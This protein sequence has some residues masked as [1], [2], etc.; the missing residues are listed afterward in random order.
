MA[1]NSVLCKLPIDII[2]WLLLF[3]SL[4][5]AFHVFIS[6]LE[7]FFL[8]LSLNCIFTVLVTCGAIFVILYVFLYNIS[9]CNFLIF[10]CLY[11]MYI[12]ISLSVC[13]SFHPSACLSVRTWPSC[14]NQVCHPHCF[15]V[16]CIMDICWFYFLMLIN[17]CGF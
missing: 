9:L 2:N 10:L 11:V 3:A 14:H 12:Y 6:Y 4:C 1:Y 8:K 15:R 7:S 17:L 13:P 16:C 5:L